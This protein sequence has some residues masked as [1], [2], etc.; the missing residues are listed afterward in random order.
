MTTEMMKKYTEALFEEEEAF[1]LYKH[2]AI[3]ETGSNKVKIM[4]IMED[5]LKHY[6]TVHN[7]IFEM[8]DTSPIAEAFKDMVVDNLMKMKACMEKLKTKTAEK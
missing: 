5:E 3:Q 4:D 2:I 7:I 8:K 1:W 6:E